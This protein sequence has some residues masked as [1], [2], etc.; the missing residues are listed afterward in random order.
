MRSIGDSAK[1]KRLLGWEPK[2]KF[3]EGMRIT[4]DWYKAHSK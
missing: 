2:V 1:A 4:Y 3:E